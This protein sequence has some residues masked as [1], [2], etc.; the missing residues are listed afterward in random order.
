MENWKTDEWFRLRV[1]MASEAPLRDRESSLYGIR[2]QQVY[3]T[4]FDR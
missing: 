4:D 1:R 3:L 2:L